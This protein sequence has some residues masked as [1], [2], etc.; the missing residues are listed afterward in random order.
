MDGQ[1]KKGQQ[2]RDTLTIS[3]KGVPRL[4]QG[5]SLMI[6]IGGDGRHFD[7]CTHR[8]RWIIN[9]AAGTETS[10]ITAYLYLNRYKIISPRHNGTSWP[11]R[12]RIPEINHVAGNNFVP[13]RIALGTRGIRA[14]WAI[15]KSVRGRSC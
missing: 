6:L 1:I 12:I 14:A 8:N 7:A 4:N 5:V 13:V 15:Q 10:S 2:K 11:R 3:R 9:G